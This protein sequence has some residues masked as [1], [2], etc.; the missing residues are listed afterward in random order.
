MSMGFLHALPQSQPALALVILLATLVYEDG[1]TLLAA[2]L[3]ASGRLD[4]RFA[5]ATTFLGIWVG[6][7]G[8]YALG[9]TLGRRLAWSTPL[10]KHLTPESLSRAERWFAQHGSFALVMSRAI[11]GS[12]LPLYTAAGALRFSGRAFAK[13]T[14][15]CSAIWVS[16][17]FAIWRFAPNLSA[18]HGTRSSFLITVAL[19]LGPWGIAKVFGV[20]RGPHEQRVH[21]VIADTTCAL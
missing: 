1:A 3:S 12:R 18:S 15:A 20:L 9:S 6:D 17:I 21:R 7:L 8:L 2:S 13:T 10:R 11:P 4:P 14:A 16:A 19:V 5:L